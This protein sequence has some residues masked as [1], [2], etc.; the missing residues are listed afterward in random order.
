MSEN[1]TSKTVRGI[2]WNSVATVSNAI[3]QLG[4]SAIIARILDPGAFGLMAMSAVVLGFG[5][6]FAQMG[7]GQ[8]LI[9]KEHLSKEDIQVAFTSSF[10]LGVIFFALGWI[11]APLS[12]HIF[13]NP[14]LVSVL[15]ITCFTL[16][17]TGL[18]S[19]STS[20]LRRN[21]EFKRLAIV[22]IASY[23]VGYVFVGITLAYLGYGVW[24]LVY[25]GICQSLLVTVLSYIYAPHSLSLSF[26]WKYYKPLFDFGSKMSFIS[27]LDFLGTNLDAFL[28]GR[29]LGE[30][31]LGLYN[32]AFILIKQPVGLVVQTVSRVLFP[33]FSRI[34]SEIERLK[35]VY[36]FSVS[37][38]VLV[39]F[40]ICCSISVASEQ[41]VNIMLG[42]KWAAAVPILQVLAFT[43]PFRVLMHFSGIICDATGTLTFKAML[44]IFYFVA[45]AILF[46]MLKSFG[47]MGFAYAVLLA[48][49]LKNFGYYIITKR[50]LKYHASELLKAYRPGIFAA[51]ISC[52]F[53]YLTAFA[54]KS[55]HLPDVVI[56]LGEVLAAIIGWLFS[57]YLNPDKSLLMEII[58]KAGSG[59]TKNNPLNQFLNKALK[60]LTH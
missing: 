37:S 6:Y 27:F 5:A 8:A 25:A 24:S 45:L 3:I 54:L 58:S 26:E 38:V 13:N 34:Q 55:I 56:L 9:N 43:T 33:A 36:L 49:L 53:V 52:A 19:T 23:L 30:T 51:V 1:L 2:K 22:Q 7:M 20:L 47:I 59:L 57:L 42:E 41:I 40:P 12:V 31:S 4:H 48:A 14:E 50:I 39:V 16:L 18:N 32:R 10:I 29:F 46:F 11:C 15:R 44:H 28:I 60:V 17:I 21:L 35:K